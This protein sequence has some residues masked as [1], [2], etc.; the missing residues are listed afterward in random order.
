MVVLT[1]T[2]TQ[3]PHGAPQNTSVMPFPTCMMFSLGETERFVRGQRW[4]GQGT[5]S[6]FE[7]AY[8]TWRATNCTFLSD[9]E[10][11]TCSQLDLSNMW[12]HPVTSSHINLCVCVY[13]RECSTRNAE[14]IAGVNC[15]LYYVFLIQDPLDIVCLCKQRGRVCWHSNPQN[16]NPF[17]LT[18]FVHLCLAPTCCHR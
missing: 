17:E 2:D 14:L 7:V 18:S 5:D 3:N 1:W 12:W 16:T 13:G 6:Q 4:G 11:S 10:Q 9:F 15:A 8:G